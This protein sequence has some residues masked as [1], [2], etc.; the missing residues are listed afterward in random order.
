MNEAS[1][2]ARLSEEAEGRMARYLAAHPKDG[3]GAHRYALA[4]AR[5]DAATE[6]KRYAAYQEHFRVPDETLP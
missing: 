2:R 6:R 4:G 1:P 3:E 5:L